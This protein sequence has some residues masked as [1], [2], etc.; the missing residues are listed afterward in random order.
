MINK[1]DDTNNYNYIHIA[2]TPTHSKP[3]CQIFRFEPFIFSSELVVLCFESVNNVKL[4]I[5]D[6]VGNYIAV[7]EVLNIKLLF[8]DS[9]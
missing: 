1:A 6:F 7:V 3:L 8:A 4:Y 2:D 5:C 9:S